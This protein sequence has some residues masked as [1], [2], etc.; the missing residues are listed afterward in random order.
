MDL[1]SYLRDEK[2]IEH[3]PLSNISVSSKEKIS[4]LFSNELGPIIYCRYWL[5]IKKELIIYYMN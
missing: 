3:T 4:T 1:I 2:N 5:I